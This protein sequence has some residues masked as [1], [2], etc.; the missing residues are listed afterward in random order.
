MTEIPA[1]YLI[2]PVTR[3]AH[4]YVPGGQFRHEE[5]RDLRRVRKRL[6]VQ[7]RQAWNDGHGLVGC[8]VEF[9]MVRAEVTR[10]GLGVLRF[11]ECLV[12]EADRE[13]FHRSLTLRMHW[14]DDCARVDTVREESH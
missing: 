8:D 6:I 2:T 11:V 5:C 4:L 9:R 7:G 14:R 12:L 3:Q 13:R 10:H 1:K